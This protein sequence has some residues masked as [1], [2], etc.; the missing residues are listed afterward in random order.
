MKAI[1]LAAGACERL[2]PLTDDIPKSLLKIG[3]KTIL[4]SQIDVFNKLK[5]NPI[6]II[7]GYQSNNFSKRKEKLFY[8]RDYKNNNILESLFC[9]QPAINGDC[10]I[11]YSDIVFK[12]N[13]VEELLKCKEDISIIVDKDWKK[14]YINRSMHP[15]S[16]AEKV[17]FDIKNNLIEA[18]KTIN[19]DDVDGEFIGMLKLSPLGCNIFN[20]YY[21]IAKNKF[22]G[23]RFYEAESF[24]KSYITDFLNYLISNNISI[25]CIKI[26]GGWMEIDTVQDYNKAQNFF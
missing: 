9:A 19:L 2:R 15:Y 7:V 22:L 21:E 14:S 13:I 24:A 23:K 8:N 26:Q 5:I 20:K 18:G 11:S 10:I 3:S 17:K 4:D 12:K 16:E 6:N 1:I 25:K